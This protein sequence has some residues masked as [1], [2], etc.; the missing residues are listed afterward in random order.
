MKSKIVWLTILVLI[1]P[2]LTSATTDHIVISEIQTYGQ[3]AGD[4]FIRLSNPTGA[5]IDISGWKLT[6]KTG[7]GAESNLVAK[8]AD[9][10]IIAPQSFF[11]IT[12]QSGYLG[13][14]SANATYSGASFSI[15][16]NNTIILK[17][18][19]GIVIDK[20]GFGAAV[21]FEGAAAKNPENGK[22]IKRNN[23]IDTDNNKN[24]FA[25]TATSETNSE[26]TAASQEFSALSTAEYGDIIINEAMPNPAEGKEWIELYNVSA[27]TINIENWKISDGSTVIFNLSGDISSNSFLTIEINNR[28]NNTGDAIYLSDAGGQSISQ[29]VYGD[30][31]NSIISA[32]EKGQSLARGDDG[33]YFISDAPT[34]NLKNKI[35]ATIKASNESAT[36]TPN[37]NL[38]NIEEYISIAEILPNSTDGDTENEYIKLKN[39]YEYDLDLGG[40]YLDDSE[41]GSN[42]F[43]I[44]AGTIIA[45]KNFLT[46]YRTKTKLALNNNEDSVRLL[47]P[48][49]KEILN[50]SYEDAKEG[51]IYS[52]QN[53]K[54]R[55]ITDTK[56]L[57]AASA[58][59]PSVVP[60]KAGSQPA[61]QITSIVIVLPNI[62]SSQTMYVDGRQL[63]MYSRDWP[64]LAVG[65]KITASG[66]P[67]TY[68]NEPRL[69]LKNKNSIKILSRGNAVA[70]TEITPEDID[71][72]YVGKFVSLEGEV[73]EKTPQKI[74]LDSN[75]IE[76]EIY[77]KTKIELSELKI[78]DIVKI[79]GILSKY[80]DTYR[81][82]PRD[83]N[84]FKT[85]KTA[86]IANKKG[87]DI[88]PDIWQYL[89][90]TLTIGAIAG[91]IYYRK[92]KTT[93]EE[94]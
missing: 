83:K 55:W 40:F 19:D 32:S 49:K 17:N 41:G 78:K 33:N 45:A 44:P 31:A 13:T 36:S 5:A 24:D 28:L 65:D 89:A 76:V 7:S 85:L 75:G 43:K 84:D 63:Y 25:A 26:T 88:P 47:L 61:N 50:I 74:I 82:L 30:W 6:K 15:A 94:K 73:L 10:T 42:P 27:R 57:P 69:K 35:T 79:S 29:L 4:E 67:S 91:V 16:N 72:E 68:Y 38:N 18:S 3:S 52:C 14:E 11:L 71:D 77:N 86:E 80:K 48:D 2:K 70:P 1:F 60:A 87:V 8:F 58:S 46:F 9:G 20:V 66:E 92:R 56:I 12:P 34:K 59:S 81:L 22:S 62:F 39:D 90:S 53:E 51:A 23:N 21:D 93:S 37:E 64:E 54:C